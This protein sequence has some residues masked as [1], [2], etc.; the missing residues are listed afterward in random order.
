MVQKASII[1]ASGY[2]GGELLRIL[3]HHPKVE[4]SDVY[5]KSTTGE[6]LTDLHPNLEGIIEKKVK[7]PDFEKIGKE[8]D[9]VFTATP[10]GT[11]MKFMPDLLEHDCK[12]VD[13]SGDYRIDDVSVFEE[14]YCEHENPD[15]ESVYGLTEINREK[16]KEANLVANPG[17]YPTAILLSVAPLLEE[18]MISPGTIIFDSKSGTSGAGAKPSEKLHFPNCSDNIRA[19]NVSSHRHLPEI[20]QEIEK[21]MREKVNVDFTPHLIPTIR[22]ILNTS[23][24]YLR[25][26]ASIEELLELYEKYYQEEFFVRIRESQPQTNAVRGSNFCDITLRKSE[27]KLTVTSAIDNLVKGASGQAVQNMNL[28]LGID[29]KI[30]LEEIPLHP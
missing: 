21:I 16:I 24:T 11:S 13:L 6:N 9:I 20:K 30:G 19:Y 18:K 1:G 27:E 7:D 26:E 12:V 29:E 5:G 10:H 14:Y 2:T 17:C 22:G 28:L 15:I 8:S 4:V 3:H 25:K 23:H